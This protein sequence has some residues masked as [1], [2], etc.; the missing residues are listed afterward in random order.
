MLP[1]AYKGDG[2]KS[3]EA[4]TLLFQ[5]H[6]IEAQ[7][8]SY[9]PLCDIMSDPYQFLKTRLCIICL[10][11]VILCSKHSYNKQHEI[12]DHFI[13]DFTEGLPVLCG[14]LG[15]IHQIRCL[16]VYN[17]DGCIVIVHSVRVL[18]MILASIMCYYDH[19]CIGNATVW[20]WFE[21]KLP[22]SSKSRSSMEEYKT[23]TL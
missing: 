15:A 5:L 9:A 22:H 11:C 17:G 1:G 20:I 7:H 23:Y 4:F 13:V 12:S 3:V 8:G 18:V 14:K 2:L 16:W 10:H 6:V 19:E 21:F